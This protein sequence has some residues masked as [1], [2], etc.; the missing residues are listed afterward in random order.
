M[1]AESQ[2]GFNGFKCKNC[3][4]YECFFSIGS[5]R[6]YNAFCQSDS[7]ETFIMHAEDSKSDEMKFID[8]FQ[9]MARDIISFR[10]W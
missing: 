6:H 8:N 10:K 4:G 3:T 7:G 1:G 2:G 5:T 9:K